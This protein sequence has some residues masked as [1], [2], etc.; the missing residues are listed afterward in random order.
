MEKLQYGHHGLIRETM[1]LKL[2]LESGEVYENND[3]DIMCLY[4][5]EGNNL[6]WAK[7]ICDKHGNASELNNINTYESN[8]H[9]FAYNI[10]VRNTGQSHNLLF[11]RNLRFE[12]Y[13]QYYI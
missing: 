1:M 12:D 3:G 5:P 4:S 6:L 9:K 10:F 8:K 11:K 7:F 2:P 13:P